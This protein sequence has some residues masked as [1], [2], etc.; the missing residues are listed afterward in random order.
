MVFLRSFLLWFVNSNKLLICKIIV[1]WYGV[2]R[3]SY[4]GKVMLVMRG[5]VALSIVLSHDVVPESDKASYLKIEKTL[6]MY[7]LKM[8]LVTFITKRTQ[9]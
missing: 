8:L 1:K 9:Q 5:L 7:I 4:F 2:S 3:P 6:V